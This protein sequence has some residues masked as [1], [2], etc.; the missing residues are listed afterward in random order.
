VKHWLH[1]ICAEP[2]GTV[3]ACASAAPRRARSQHEEF[4]RAWE[5]KLEANGWRVGV[6]G[7]DMFTSPEDDKAL[8]NMQFNANL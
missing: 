1:S 5:Q 7:G 3:G 2:A 6:L 8:R 4:Q